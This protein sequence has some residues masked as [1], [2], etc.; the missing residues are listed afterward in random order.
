[1]AVIAFSVQARD[2]NFDFIGSKY[3]KKTAQEKFDQMWEHL[4]EDTTGLTTY[5]YED[6]ANLFEQDM[7]PSTCSSQDIIK[8]SMYNKSLDKEDQKIRHKLLHTFGIVG[9]VEYEAADYNLDA[10]AATEGLRYTGVFEGADYGVIRLSETGFM[11][12][13]NQ[14][15]VYSP[16]LAIKFFVSGRSSAD[17]HF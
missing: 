5:Y 6:M 9:S 1:V 13:D 3:F 2:P 17:M 7:S 12:N 11:L 8:K 16:S 15:Q 10:F 4:M 14:A